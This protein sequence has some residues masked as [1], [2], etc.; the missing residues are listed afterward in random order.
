MLQTPGA[1]PHKESR[2]RDLEAGVNERGT[3]IQPGVKE[4]YPPQLALSH[5]ASKHAQYN[6]RNFRPNLQ[7]F[8]A[9]DAGGMSPDH[10]NQATY[11]EPAA[12]EAR[13]RIAAFF[14]THLD[15]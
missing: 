9:H 4:L 6:R 14:Q 2:I 12:M 7:T 5:R 15:T 10:R 8:G 1:T 11:N 13:K 3:Q